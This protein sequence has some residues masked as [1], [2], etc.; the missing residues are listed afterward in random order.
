MVNI[1]THLLKVVIA[2]PENTAVPRQW[3]CKQVSTA[4]NSRDSSNRHE[5]NT[6]GTDGSGVFCGVRPEA[7]YQELKPNPSIKH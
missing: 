5:R 6:R 3:L 2:E 4:T 1:V 7:V